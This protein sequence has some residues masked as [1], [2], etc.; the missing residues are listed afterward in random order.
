MK[1]ILI[2][3]VATLV[4]FLVI[5]GLYLFTIGGTFYKNHIG[6][7]MSPSVS[8]LP[9]GLFYLIYVAGML[10]LVVL[11]ALKSGQGIGM[12]FLMGAVL[13]F[14]AYATYDLT[15]QA[16]LRDWPVIVTA[17]DLAWGAFVTG[18]ASAIAVLISRSWN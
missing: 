1:T 6:H 11:P 5:D 9:A 16:S 4:P 14:V 12:T 18:T 2:S 15:N 8:F 17:I 7:L 3:F 13:G 10:A